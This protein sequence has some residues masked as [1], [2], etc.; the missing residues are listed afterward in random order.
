MAKEN[1]E[2]KQ[3]FD[4][5]QS[6]EAILKEGKEDS[7]S[8]RNTYHLTKDETS[9][10][11]DGSNQNHEYPVFRI[12]AVK[13]SQLENGDRDR[14]IVGGIGRLV[15]FRTKSLVRS[16]YPFHIEVNYKGYPSIS[17]INNNIIHAGINLTKLLDSL[18]IPYQEIIKRNEFGEFLKEYAKQSIL[19][20]QKLSRKK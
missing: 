1:K 20:A 19:L 14:L 8:I 3:N 4:A 2:S 10:V 9:A 6:L 18:R 5:L 16:D 13:L 11:F 7:E 17:G 15:D 12:V